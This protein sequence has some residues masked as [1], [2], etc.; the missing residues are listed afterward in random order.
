MLFPLKFLLSSFE[1]L[2][3]LNKLPFNLLLL[4]L[5]PIL[6]VII[7]LNLLFLPFVEFAAFNFSKSCAK[8][9]LFIT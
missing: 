8:E 2:F 1:L 4:I 7:L 6:S 5:E 9:I 3:S